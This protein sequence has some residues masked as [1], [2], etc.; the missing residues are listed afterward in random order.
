MVDVLA[1]GRPRPLV[2]QGADVRPRVPRTL[3][4]AARGGGT[5]RTRRTGWRRRKA[6]SR[7]CCCST[8]SRATPSAARRACTPPMRWRARSPTPPST[9]ATTGRWTGLQVFFYLPFGHSEDLADQERS[10]ALNRRLGEPNCPIA[11]RHRDIIR[12]FGRFPHRNPILG[13]TDAAGGAAVPR[14][15]RLRGLMR[16]DGHRHEADQPVRI[17]RAVGRD[18]DRRRL[19]PVLPAVAPAPALSCRAPARASDEARTAVWDGAPNGPPISDEE[20]A[21]FVDAE[22]T[23]RFP[24]GLTVLRGPGQWRDRDGVVSREQSHILVI[25]HAPTSRHETDIEAIRRPRH[26]GSTRRA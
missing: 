14:R 2:R 21:A 18:C 7:W 15:R 12:R 16:A 23:P 20:W 4:V 3:P 25:W 1:R 6:R 9:P 24:D 17:R 10:V 19:C 5:R 11:E 8:S 26:R 22:V 13:R